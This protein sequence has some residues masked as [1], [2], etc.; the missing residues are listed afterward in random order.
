MGFEEREID[1]AA[2]TVG[3]RIETRISE[4]IRDGAILELS[5]FVVGR[6]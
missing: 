3:T 4:T 1:A 5:V 6:K 2:D